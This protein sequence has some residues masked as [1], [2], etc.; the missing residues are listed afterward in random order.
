MLNLTKIVLIVTVA[1]A[2]VL[3]LL[4]YVFT[5]ELQQLIEGNQLAIAAAVVVAIGVVV[6]IAVMGRQ[7]A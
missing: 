7:K 1:M 6:V 2:A 5:V 4:D 3:G